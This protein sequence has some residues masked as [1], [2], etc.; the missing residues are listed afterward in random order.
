MRLLFADDHPM[1][2][3]AVREHLTRAFPDIEIQAAS[4]LDEVTTKLSNRGDYDLVV[5]DFSMPGMEGTEGVKRL[6]AT[7]PDLAIAV[8]SGVA[9]TRD[10]KT[11]LDLG[12]HGFLPK[13]LTGSAYAGALRVI[14]EGGTYVPVET[15]QALAAEAADRKIN[16][17]GLT[18]REMEV[19]E[20][21]ADGKPNKQIARDLEIHEVTVKLHARS[22]FKKIGVQNRSQAAVVARE[23]GLVSRGYVQENY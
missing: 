10:V 21:I 14:A 3:D 23:R 5:L 8:T 18:P 20:G 9:K 22:I 11:V 7:Y 1:F 2:L 17:E 13:T 6:R 12:A 16:A 4:N 19:L 15:M